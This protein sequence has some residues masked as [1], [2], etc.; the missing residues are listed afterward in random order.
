VTRVGRWLRAGDRWAPLLA[1][2]FGV[3]A[4][5]L[6]G[7][8]LVRFRTDAPLAI[9]EAAYLRFALDDRA[10][11]SHGGLGG[12]WDAIVSQRQHAPLVPAVSVPV[13]LVIGSRAAAA[14]VVEEA[15][16]VLLAVCAWFVARR[17]LNRRWALLATVVVIGIPDVTYW[18]RTL[19]FGVPAT[20]LFL[21]A[22]LALLESDRLRNLWWS[23]AFGA[24]L[25]FAVLT[26]TIMIAFVPGLVV[27]AAIAAAAVGEEW[28]RRALHLVIALAVGVSVAATWW[29][30]NWSVVTAYLKS[31]G[32]GAAS[33]S[34]GFG[35]ATTDP[36][37]LKFW[38]TELRSGVDGLGLPLSVLL[39]AAV[40]LAI[41]ARRRWPA[42]R[43]VL[44]NDR[45]VLVVTLIAGYLALTSTENKTPGFGTPL[46][47]LVALL[48]VLALSELPWHAWRR[49]FAVG[50]A[51]VAAAALVMQASI[52]DDLSIDRFTTI[53]VIGRVH[54][55]RGSSYIKSWIATNGRYPNGGPTGRVPGPLRAWMPTSTRAARCI[56]TQ[57]RH[58]GR[59]PVVFFATRDPLFNTNTLALEARAVLDA[60]LSV[61]QITAA[62]GRTARARETWY[63][64]HLDAPVYGWPNLLVTGPPA[65]GEYEPRADQREVEHAARAVGFSPA[66]AVALPDGRV[67]R[68]WWLDRGAVT[69]SGPSVAPPQ[70]GTRQRTTECSK[71]PKQ[72]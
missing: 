42:A 62:P 56:A 22:I 49:A 9:D 33:S 30:P 34:Y 14:F 64:R 25:G 17:F 3:V 46:L 69:G 44:A 47:P 38:T 23:I 66:F 43:A 51:L 67:T 20:A 27:A 39:V 13:Q 24:L 60:S 72:T 5:T 10:G 32:Y 52:V 35:R 31:T 59:L 57:A 54:V 2:L 58:Y 50:L 37:A 1:T 40:V 8:W 11:L 28:R 48:G 70:P 18:T 16:F 41:S 21:A 53:P 55:V 26:R 19:L 12:L 36:F 65:P 63:R 61:G 15:F 4:V 6:N 68:W 45:T 7:L 29:G 71:S